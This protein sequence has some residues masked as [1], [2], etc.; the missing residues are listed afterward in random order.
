[1]EFW[2]SDNAKDRFQLPVQPSSF[3][4]TKSNTNQTV[5]IQ[6]LGEISLLGKENLATITIASF[7]PKNEYYFCQ[8]TG[9]PAPYDCVKKIEDWRKSEK[10]IKLTITSTDIDLL[11]SIESFKYGEKEEGTGDVYYTLELKEYKYV[12]ITTQAVSL[13]SRSESKVS[14]PKYTVKAGD[15]LWAIAMK[16]YGDGSK[17]TS[18]ASKNGIKNPNL[19]YPGQVLIL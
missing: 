15:T 14:E 3:E 12:T 5:S 4:I 19:I 6:D 7:F 2:L 11:V 17:Y 8:Y 13:K 1:M 9:F 18:L 10:P 16:Q